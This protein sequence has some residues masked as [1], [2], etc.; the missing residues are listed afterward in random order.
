[1]RGVTPYDLGSG[2][3]TL[4]P[5]GRDIALFQPGL[6]AHDGCRIGAEWEIRR[7]LAC[8]LFNDG[9]YS[10]TPTVAG[11]AV[12]AD[13]LALEH[14]VFRIASAFLNRAARIK[15]GALTAVEGRD[16]LETALLGTSNRA[17]LFRGALQLGRGA[18]ATPYQVGELFAAD[19]D[20]WDDID[21]G[22]PWIRVL[23]DPATG[24]VRTDDD[25]ASLSFHEGRFGRVGA[26]SHD[27]A[28]DLTAAA[29]APLGGPGQVS[30][31]T[32]PTAG[33]H[34]INDSMTYAHQVNTGLTL[35]G[36]LHV[37]AADRERPY[38]LIP[39][40]VPAVPRWV[41][42]ADQDGR[43]L[44]LDG[45]WLGMI[46]DTDPDAE[47]ADP[48]LC[49]I[50]LQGGFNR[51]CLRNV[52][53]DPGGERAWIPAVGRR[54]IPTIRLIIAGASDL[55]EIEHSVTGPIE[56]A[57]GAYT[58][59]A[60]G[61]VRITDSIV[62]GDQTIDG[63]VM[64]AFRGRHGTLEI[65]RSTLFGNIEAAL[66]YHRQH[67]P[68]HGVRPG[69]AGQL[70]PLFGRGGNRH[71]RPCQR[72][73][74]RHLRRHHAEPRFRLAPLRRRWAGTA[75]GD[76]SGDGPPR[77]REHLRDG[78]AQSRARRHQAR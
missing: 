21:V 75:L 43:D 49:E 32:F 40:T 3:Y 45:L 9:R 17:A 23:V 74:L 62:H 64:P 60:A 29:P 67:H 57:L 14:A 50:V 2:R 39:A 36:D 37:Q 48:V 13:L 33:E 55:I 15:G 5:S 4:D 18:A 26:G 41:I 65:K 34:Q 47:G 59:C 24:R 7:P 54:A 1:L 16:L 58:Q 6:P 30:G 31:F 69:S 52:T 11:A 25:L 42:D 73:S 76:R 22:T 27:R 44:T 10:V 68:G 71:H 70:H 72:L 53:L 56:E 63:A 51:V 46:R 20:V 8:A 66:R 35:D 19:L 77:C 12:G 78:C 28:S 61:T 38:I